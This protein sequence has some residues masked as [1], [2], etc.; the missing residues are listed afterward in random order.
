MLNTLPLID[1]T[2]SQW[3]ERVLSSFDDFLLD[4]A[5]CERKAAALATS[6]IAKYPDRTFLIEPMVSLARE[7]LEHFAEVYRII[8]KRKINFLPSDEKDIYVNKVLAQLRHGREE[9]FLDRLIMSGIVEARGWERF[10]LLAE[11]LTDEPLQLFYH[12]LA[13][14]ELGH[15]KIFINI[16]HKYFSE[17]EVDLAISRI[18]EVE[19]E[20]MLTTP[21]SSRLH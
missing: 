6:F 19:S 5:S 21:L 2:P 20:A 16:A 9:R 13:Q 3:V 8:N 11:H 4:H 1:K 18:A 15:Y 7:E 12:R 17:S 14:R 10:N